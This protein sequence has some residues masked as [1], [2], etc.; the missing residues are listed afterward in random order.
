VELP[1]PLV[2]P[3]WLDEHLGAP[4]LVV[5]DCRWYADGS[6]RARFERTHLPGAVFVDADADLAAPPEGGRG[7][8]PLPSPGDFAETMSA[9]GIGDADAVV[10]Y[11]DAGGSI[12]SRLWWM[13]DA[14]GHR[15]AVLDGVLSAWDG[16][17]ETGP[18][19]R[20]RSVFTPHT[21]AAQRV[22]DTPAAVEIVGQGDGVLIDARSGERYRG[23]AEP[24]DARAGHIPG[25]VNAPWASNLDP[26]TGRFL[27]PGE[28][29]RRYEALGVRDAGGAVAYCGSGLTATHDVL[30]MR[31][32]G[33][34]TARLYEGSWSGW[35][36]DPDRP[37]STGADP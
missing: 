27:P 20:P 29:R 25:A 24:I 18:V 36:H 33:L 19:S 9:L 7:R 14:T 22:V 35:S 31:V 26:D 21:W 28:L 2:T 16:P 11:D 12:A 30:A 3:D 23:E 6:G 8:H 13:L 10:A 1:G 37:G 5:A 32:A 34:G 15:A 4:G 17:L